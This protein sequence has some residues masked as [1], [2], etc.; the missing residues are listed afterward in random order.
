[1]PELSPPAA[2]D[3]ALPESTSR[4]IPKNVPARRLRKRRNSEIATAIADIV[5]SPDPPPQPSVERPITP[6]RVTRAFAAGTR[7]APAE[8]PYARKYAKKTEIV[9]ESTLPKFSMPTST[10]DPDTIVLQYT[11][12]AKMGIQ[13]SKSTQGKPKT[14]NLSNNTRANAICMVDLRGPQTRASI[15][16]TIKHRIPDARV[17]EEREDVNQAE[18]KQGNVRPKAWLNGNDSPTLAE[19]LTEYSE[20]SPQASSSHRVPSPQ[21]PVAERDTSE[22]SEN[23]RRLTDERAQVSL[24]PE[25][26][27]EGFREPYASTFFTPHLDDYDLPSSVRAPPLYYHTELPS[28]P[29]L[30]DRSLST[31]VRPVPMT[32]M[33]D[34]SAQST[35]RTDVL[36]NADIAKLLEPMTDTEGDGDEDATLSSGSDGNTR[37]ESNSIVRFPRDAT[38]HT[39][40]EYAV[41]KQ[42]L[43][44]G[45]EKQKEVQGRLEASLE[46]Q[47]TMVKAQEDFEKAEQW[48]ERSGP[49][50]W[51]GTRSR[52]GMTADGPDFLEYLRAKAKED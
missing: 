19:K 45:L 47:K 15:G 21:P 1:M 34:M 35:I 22:S 33:V 18:E 13:A 40:A 10:I 17:E 25:P 7:P 37:G 4:D 52:G 32:S 50:R 12:Q 43:K 48:G 14:G 38:E 49:A 42:V 28:H 6:V 41:L 31:P 2:G 20:A 39:A 30:P 46:D 5:P 44:A 23:E 26:F 3:N 36:K 24:G 27:P 8:L 29:P 11:G 9:T 16:R 51:A